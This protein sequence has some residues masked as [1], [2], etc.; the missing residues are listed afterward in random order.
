MDA[1]A[2]DGAR[3]A[4]H[5]DLAAVGLCTRCGSFVCR[6]CRQIDVK[7]DSY[8]PACYGRLDRRSTASTFA[9]AAAVLGFFGLG[10][11]PLGAIAVVMAGIDLARIAMGKSPTGGKTLNLIGLGL[12]LLGVLLGI[13]IVAKNGAEWLQ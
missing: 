11:F 8:C 9:F 3:C 12:G 5:I 1:A 10:C 6:G 7:G 4:A 13:A 2:P